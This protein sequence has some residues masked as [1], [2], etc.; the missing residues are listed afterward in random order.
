M[1]PPS[2]INLCKTVMLMPFRDIAEIAESLVAYDVAR[3]AIVKF[4]S[5]FVPAHGTVGGK[6][7]RLNERGEPIPPSRAE[8]EAK[9][10]PAWL[11][12]NKMPVKT[13]DVEFRILRAYR[14]DMQVPSR[15]QIMTFVI[16]EKE[17]TMV[18]RKTLKA[19][20]EYNSAPLLDIAPI[21]W[22]EAILKALSGFSGISLL[23]SHDTR[24][25][26]HREVVKAGLPPAMVDQ[27]LEDASAGPAQYL[28]P[29]AEEKVPFNPLA[30]TAFK[31]ME[32][33]IPPEVDLIAMAAQQ[34]QPTAAEVMKI[35]NER[36]Q[37][38]QH[39]VEAATLLAS[40]QKSV[41]AEETRQA[42]DEAA[43]YEAAQSGPDDTENGEAESPAA[44]GPV[45]EP[46]QET[47]GIEQ[48]VDEEEAEEI[49]LPVA[50]V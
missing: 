28:Q 31:F 3:D 10:K 24:A 19:E 27:L 33:D 23:R 25:Q 30:A 48:A 37:H 50:P 40:V 8:A 15:F 34:Q 13:Q 38:V 2:R 42:E 45:T 35:I 44:E 16:P 12:Y 7:F 1:A 9:L 36:P 39:I 6:W 14:H 11:E 21:W 43:Q 47:V 26:V 4:I 46:L 17:G 18:D 32:G 41:D 20:S 29:A 49:Q 22:H 5:C